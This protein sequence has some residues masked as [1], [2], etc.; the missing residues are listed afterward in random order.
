[1][2][3]MTE[4]LFIQSKSLA[5][6]LIT[7]KEVTPQ[8]EAKVSV[9]LNNLDNGMTR[10]VEHVSNKVDERIVKSIE[11]MSAGYSSV[12]SNHN[13]SI[14]TH[15]N[16]LQTVSSELK[17]SMIQTIAEHNIQATKFVEDLKSGY[18][19]VLASH[20]D[21]IKNFTSTVQSSTAELKDLL[22]ATI[23]DNQKI[24]NSGLEDSLVKIRD[25][26]TALDKGLE[27]ELTRSLESLSHQLAS[28]SAKFV[29]DYSPL[30]DRLR[31]VVKIAE[32]LRR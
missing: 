30:T 16:S 21:S 8:F 9:M 26:V 27:K 5:D 31:E 6:V 13:E 3:K 22:S 12:V 28:L 4:T 11:T 25:S 19:S 29:D 32:T 23:R 20:S 2:K 1:M 18:S 14:R 15:S 24:I 17:N 10:I 7:M